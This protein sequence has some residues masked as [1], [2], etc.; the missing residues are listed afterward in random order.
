M[1]FECDLH[2]FSYLYSVAS[3]FKVSELHKTIDRSHLEYR[4]QPAYQRKK[5][6][7]YG[8]KNTVQSALV[9]TATFVSND[10]AVV[11]NL[12]L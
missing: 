1:N 5:V 2:H 4:P 8:L 3:N 9:T 7:A 10:F 6:A 12:P 11:T